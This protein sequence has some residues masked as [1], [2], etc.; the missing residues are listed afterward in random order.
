[1]YVTKNASY[2]KQW[3]KYVNDILGCFAPPPKKKP[4][5]CQCLF[6]RSLLSSP[7]P[8]QFDYQQLAIRNILYK[9]DMLKSL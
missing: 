1:M 9:I 5:K 6:L 7:P 8:S 2:V 3:V 4:F